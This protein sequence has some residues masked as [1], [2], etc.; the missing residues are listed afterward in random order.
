[1]WV[2]ST[3]N[4]WNSCASSGSAEWE[5]EISSGNCFTLTIQLMLLPCKT[6]INAVKFSEGGNSER[7]Q[8]AGWIPQKQNN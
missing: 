6:F 4:Q 7:K 1:M 3:E 5:M 8:L 2:I